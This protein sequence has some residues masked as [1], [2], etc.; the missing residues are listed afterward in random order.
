MLV[1]AMAPETAVLVD[2]RNLRPRSK[3]QTAHGWS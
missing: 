2:L 3:S 1:A